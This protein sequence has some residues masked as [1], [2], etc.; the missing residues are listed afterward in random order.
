MPHGPA[1][2]WTITLGGVLQILTMVLLAVAVFNALAA[3]ITIFENTLKNHADSLKAHADR[4]D[5]HEARIIELIGTLQ[6]VIG[7]SE[8]SLHERNDRT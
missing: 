6:R 5:R 7:R 8:L 3:R 4:L 1:F 2:D